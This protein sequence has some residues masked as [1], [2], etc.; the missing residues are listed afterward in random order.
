MTRTVTLPVNVV[1]AAA[2]TL[3]RVNPRGFADEVE[4]LALVVTLEAFCA[5]PEEINQ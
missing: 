2:Q 5:Q 4:L 1:W 3:R